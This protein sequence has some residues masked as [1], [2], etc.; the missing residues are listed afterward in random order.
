MGQRRSEL[1]DAQGPA[2]SERDVFARHYEPLLRLAVLLTGSRDNAEDVVQD[3]FSKALTRIR[4]L[5]E[6]Q[7][8][9][10]LR[11]AVW[12]TWRNV[13]RR[14]AVER[15]HRPG[16]TLADPPAIED[17]EAVWGAI[18]R[19]PVRQRA[20]VVLRYYEGLTERETAQVLGCSVGTVKSQTSRAFSH[21]RKE[22]KD[23]DRR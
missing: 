17:R 18:T 20:C 15:R 6:D 19:L 9:P 22:L 3:V 12:N 23:E 13:L 16:P 10:Y 4:E 1:D 7:Q 8:F 5:P 21:L 11:A 14:R 2:R